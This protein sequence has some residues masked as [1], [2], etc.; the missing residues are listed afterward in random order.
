VLEFAAG[1]LIVAFILTS[2]DWGWHK[3]VVAVISFLIGF[4]PLISFIIADS[5]MS[6]LGC[7]RHEWFVSTCWAGSI[8]ISDL[9]TVM[10]MAAAFFWYTSPFA[11]ISI[12]LLAA[13]LV[14]WVR[15]NLAG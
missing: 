1:I 11:L 10:L 4:A 8:D 6:W 7:S 15:R 3:P 9:L 13:I 2:I 5:V 12:V 14:R